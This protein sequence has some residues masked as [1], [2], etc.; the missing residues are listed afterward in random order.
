MKRPANGQK[1]KKPPKTVK[2][3]ALGVPDRETLLAFLNQAKSAMGHRDVA[4][5]FGVK[6][7]ER[8]ALKALMHELT[9]E[10][11][12]AKT[13][14]KEIASKTVPP[15][16]GVFEIVE[17]DANGDLLARASGRDDALFGPPVR[18]A[19]TK[20]QV[21]HEGPPPGIH[22]RFVGKVRMDAQGD[23]EVLVIKRL[24][25]AVSKVFG[26][27]TATGN[28]PKEGGIVKPS[29]RKMR[30]DL[31]IGR[32]HTN[33]ARSGDLVSAKLMPHR[34][35]GPKQAE[36]L[37]IFGNTEDPKAASILAIAAHDIPMGFSPEEEDQAN[38][39]GPATLD[40]RE[41][42]RALPLFTI[43]PED[44]RD[45]DDAVFAEAL[46]DGGYRLIVAIA[47]VAFYVT[48]GSPLDEGAIKRGNSVYFPD[49]VVP[50][51]PLRLSADLCS[52][53]EGE[54]RPCLALEIVIDSSGQKLRHRFTRALMRSAASLTYGQAQNAINGIVDETTEALLEPVLKPL[55]AA[56]AALCKARD[57]RQPLE[58]DSPERKIVLGPDGKVLSIG[59]RERLD[60]HRLIEEM[61][62]LANVCAAET[63]EDKR[64]ALIYRVH[65]QPS[66]TKLAALGDFLATVNIKWAKGQPPSPSRFNAVLAH[67][68]PTEHAAMINEIVLRTQAQAIYD[69]QNLGHFGLNLTKY[70]HFTSPI[71]RYADLI[72]HRALIA[73]LGLGKD[74]LRDGDMGRL[75]RIAELITATERR[76][77]AAEREAND[78]YVAAFLS[79]R[80]GAIFEGR[81]T[82]VTRFGLFVRLNE[83]GGD[84]L[85]P[86]KALGL[87]YFHHDE[88]GHA[89][90]GERSGDRWELGAL[91]QV[92][93]LEAIPVTGGLLFEM[94]SE[95]KSSP[96]KPRLQPPHRRAN[97][98]KR[99]R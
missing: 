16:G 75:Q 15:E 54:D 39:A 93:L 72:V 63:L 90:V 69:T 19:S 24:G 86:I 45:H 37:E 27:F 9:E 46:D 17:M 26:V 74:G 4:L 53:V 60:A 18:L 94:V 23:Y 7:D 14:R 80:V 97:A 43:D 89:L 61:M 84:G 92:R 76:A 77:M 21:R 95:P 41:D 79:E 13:G 34:G 6:G 98:F 2:R 32:G 82:S 28:D 10:G 81:I 35:Y 5:A 68:K 55:W 67:A 48:P 96:T 3:Q 25:V 64:T 58:I 38:D 12:I 22:D 91:V 88:T 71:R 49:R 20:A 56:Y 99:R 70:A 1:G 73:A 52:L 11:L 47:D 83:T 57:Q 51:L 30:F 66:A 36:I 29:D 78:R 50:M 31:M 44:A 33:G 59:V 85:V 42:L 87:E 8:R 62:I 40:G 65:D